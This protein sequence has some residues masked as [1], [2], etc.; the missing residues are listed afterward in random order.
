MDYRSVLLPSQ[1]AQESPHL[2]F[3]FASIEYN[4]QNTTRRTKGWLFGIY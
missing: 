1:L 4:S 2:H 3:Y